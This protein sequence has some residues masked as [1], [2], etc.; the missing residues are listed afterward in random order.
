MARGF[1][2]TRGVDWFENYAPTLSLT[3]LRLIL[4][5]ASK[6]KLR[7]HNIDIKSAYLYG[8]VDAQV[9]ME[10]PKGYEIGATSK[11]MEEIKSIDEPVLIL[12]KAIYGL[13]NSG[14]IWNRTFN[15]TLLDMGFRRLE[16]DP[17]VCVLKIE[18]RL[19]ILGIYVDDTVI[20][21]DQQKDLE[22]VLKRIG[23][24]Y[25][26]TN[27]GPIK[28]S[29][30]MQINRDSQGNYSISQTKYI[31]RMCERFKILPS[32][33][34]RTPLPTA[35]LKGTDS[36][37]V[38]STEYRSTVGAALY[39]AVATRP[40][41]AQACSHLAQFNTEPKK[42]HLNAARR[43]MK[44]LLNTAHYKIS[45][46]KTNQNFVGYSDATHGTEKEGKSRSGY[47]L[48]LFGGPVL[49][50][51][52]RQRVLANSIAESEYM[53]MSQL[54]R[55]IVYCTQFVNEIGFP[56]YKNVPICTPIYEDCSPAISIASNPGFSQR[57]K[58][59][60]L[61]YHNVRA[62]LREQRIDIKKIKG[63]DQPADLL[64]KPLSR[65]LTIKFCK[66]LF[67]V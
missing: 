27:L 28:E 19:V 66:M 38:D 39:V 25:K 47:F 49:W 67:D 30:G 3:S 4:A 50:G 7:V 17:C 36:E 58:S 45:Y 40:D 59:I 52:H 24:E 34:A 13:R 5:L 2:Q 12:N 35:P 10:I 32:K 22:F 51:S 64:T 42:V 33:R 6:F 9:H 37:P 60:R 21:Y 54:C 48:N 55:D 20:A 62:M 29:L 44:Y 53:S 16:S 11:E 57:S 26:F 46:S 23:D 61:S 31:K 65:R 63:E 56:E 8:Q 18:D 1:T 41:I 43:L 14:Y 15:K